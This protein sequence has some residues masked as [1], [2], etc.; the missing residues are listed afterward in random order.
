MLPA[1][2]AR[3]SGT[4]ALAALTWASNPNLE[5]ALLLPPP[6]AVILLHLGMR[7]A[8]YTVAGRS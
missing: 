2:V 6:I 8:R 5:A 4:V 7:G 3:L 1:S